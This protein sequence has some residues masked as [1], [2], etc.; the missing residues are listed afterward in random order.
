MTG[1]V[2]VT[3]EEAAV[4]GSLQ[5]GLH[6]KVSLT[7]SHLL[8]LKL[9]SS[10]RSTLTLKGPKMSK[11]HKVQKIRNVKMEPQKLS[12][13]FGGD[14]NGTATLEDILAVLKKLNIDLPFEPAIAVLL[15]QMS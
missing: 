10:R 13:F 12:F 2:R 8:F 11:H 6:M 9:A 15:T 4:V 1:P 14:A 7:G 3:V 5:S